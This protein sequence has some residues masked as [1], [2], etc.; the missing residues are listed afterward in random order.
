MRTPRTS[1]GHQQLRAFHQTF[2]DEVP[3]PCA[4]TVI[5]EP[6]QVLQFDFDGNERR[7]LTAICLHPN[8]TKHVVAACDLVIPPAAP[9][10]PQL[11]AYRKWMGLAPDLNG[12][13]EL[14]VLSVK[15]NVARCR[16]LDGGGSITLRGSGRLD[17]VPAEIVVVRPEKRWTYQ[18]SPC[19]SG[20]I[21]S[22]RLDVG[23]L[24]LQPL[25]LERL[26]LWDPAEQ[27]WG[28]VGVPIGKWARLIIAR[29]PRE[30]FE[31][32][33]VIPGEDP[34]D[35]DSDPIIESNDRKDSGDAAGAH[36]ILM[37]LCLADLRCL[38]AHN[39]LGNLIFHRRPAD[40]I[41]HYEAGVRIGELSLG[42]AFDGVLAWGFLDNRPFLR[43]MHG[44]GLCLWRLGRFEETA[45][46]FHRMLWLNPTD[47]QGV[48]MMIDHVRR[49]EPWEDC[50]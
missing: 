42:P 41:R 27:Y 48:R 43:C 25:G 47:N 12:A 23:A 19:L 3:V 29:G 6:V 22:T 38:D 26:E 16:L 36:K 21:E 11:A 15:A 4:A 7:G 5:G 13:V 30:Q 40:A 1:D 18:G 9:G 49:K 37:D 8:G 44:Y 24:P 31:M 32:E 28:D 45:N 50:E 46:I 14:A 2:E 20:S 10:G 17:V 35:F 33:Q 34:Y 39:H